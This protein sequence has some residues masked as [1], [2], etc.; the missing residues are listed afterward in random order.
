MAR[1]EVSSQDA[2][3]QFSELMDRVH[4]GGERVVVTYHGRPRVAL[5]RFEDLER[6][7]E[8]EKA[9]RKPRRRSP[10]S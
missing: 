3:R 9:R 7:E 6:L 4:A 8:I 10:R 5:I 1:T 2:R